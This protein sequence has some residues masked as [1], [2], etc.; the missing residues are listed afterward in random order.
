MLFLEAPTLVKRAD[1]DRLRGRWYR[2]TAKGRVPVK[3]DWKW[4]VEE[5]SCH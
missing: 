2:P 5:P 3:S 4:E 1:K